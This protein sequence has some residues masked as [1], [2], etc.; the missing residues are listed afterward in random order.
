MNRLF[1]LFCFILIASACKKQNNTSK[2][3]ML[4]HPFTNVLILGN[5]IT[6]TPANPSSGWNG[7]WGMAASALEKDYVH[8]L[9]A[10]FKRQSINANVTAKNIAEFEVNY[11]TYNFDTELKTYRDKK[12]DLLI[13]RIGENV[14]STFD[15][16]EFAKRYQGLIAYM[17]TDNP[18]LKVLAVGSIWYLPNKDYINNIMSRY[19][20]YI[21]L[22]PLGTD[23]SNF[24]FDMQNV[25]DGVKQHPGDKGMQA[26]SD[27]IW[28][29]VLTMIN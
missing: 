5:S 6:Y 12:P 26:I 3:V 4:E 14:Q 7:N 28:K 13:L 16:V 9:A 19:T 15:S 24:A 20:P 11:M 23:N 8:L 27:V 1:T 18:Q 25:S 22:A 29:K 17:K 21:S 10:K 2:E